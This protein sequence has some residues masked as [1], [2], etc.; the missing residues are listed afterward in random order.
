MNQ[1]KEINIFLDFIAILTIAFAIAY[2]FKILFG[3]TPY[4]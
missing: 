2:F 4:N 3:G 1:K